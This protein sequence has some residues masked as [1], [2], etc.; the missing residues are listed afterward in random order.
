MATL[1]ERFAAFLSPES[2]V[3]KKALPQVHLTGPSYASGKKDNFKSFASEGY[4]ENAIV[5]RCVNEIANGA[6]T[7]EFNLFQGDNRVESHPLLSL[8]RRP[9]PLQAGVEYFQSLYSLSLIHI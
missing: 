9:N 5:Y 1:R 3:E 2:F 4:K 8:L 7:I 6:S